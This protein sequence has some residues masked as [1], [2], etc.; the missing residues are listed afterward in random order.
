MSDDPTP[1]ASFHGAARL[2]PLPSLVLFPH[3]VQPLHIFEPR[4]RQMTADALDGDRLIALALLQPGWEEDYDNRPPIHEVVCLGRIFNEER[5]DDGR[6]NLLLHGLSRARILEETASGKLYRTAR[7]KVLAEQEP[8][9]ETAREL[10]VELAKGVRNWIASQNLA[11]EQLGKLLNSNLSLGV[12][13]DIFS[14]SLPL[15]VERKQ[16]LLAETDVDRRCRQLLH[17]LEDQAPPA[18]PAPPPTRRYPAEFSEN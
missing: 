7:L 10:R 17:H 16:Q 6:F 2:F 5:L 13:C 15:E 3:I 1:L 12:L 4:Y 14:Y 18:P 9:E 8:S 11:V